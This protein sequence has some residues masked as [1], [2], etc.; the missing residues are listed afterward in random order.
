MIANDPAPQVSMAD[1][2]DDNQPLPKP[3]PPKPINRRQ[4]SATT[5]SRKQSGDENAAPLSLSARP[6]KKS[7]AKGQRPHSQSL[8]H[9]PNQH[10]IE[11]NVMS[12]SALVSSNRQDSEQQVPSQPNLKSSRKKNR[13]EGPKKEVVKGEASSEAVAPGS[14]EPSSSNHCHDF[15]DMMSRSSNRQRSATAVSKKHSGSRDE[16]AAPLAASA[17]RRKQRKQTMAADQRPSIEAL[18]QSV[19]MQPTQE[20]VVLSALSNSVL[21]PSNQSIPQPDP[22]LKPRTSSTTKKRRP[23]M[24][25]GSKKAANEPKVAERLEAD[26]EIAAMQQ[27]KGVDQ[28]QAQTFTEVPLTEDSGLVPQPLTVQPLTAESLPAASVSQPQDELLV[29]ESQSM[30]P[31]D[32][33]QQSVEPSQSAPAQ[34]I[35]PSQSAAVINKP[36]ESQSAAAPQ[37]NVP[38]AAPA[39]GSLPYAVS[40]ESS[41]VDSGATDEESE[42]DEALGTEPKPAASE[43][44]VPHTSIA[45]P[46]ADPSSGSSSSSSSSSESEHSHK[47][48]SSSEDQEKSDS[49]DIGLD[50]ALIESIESV[51]IKKKPQPNKKV[52]FAGKNGSK[53]DIKKLREPSVNFT[54]MFSRNSSG[55]YSPVSTSEGSAESPRRR[56]NQGKKPMSPR[57]SVKVQEPLPAAMAAAHIHVDQTASSAA[58]ANEPQSSKDLVD[59]ASSIR[60]LML[61]AIPAALLLVL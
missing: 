46:P 18:S 56:H 13:D 50:D 3:A 28:N 45:A 6:A 5:G 24:S 29:S 12:R 9:Q 16:N 8:V 41:A 60:P 58:A 15:E 25:K 19:I 30:G 42:S 55:P 22:E 39:D 33:A 49:E 32:V 51:E 34:P 31:S 23:G 44:P 43:I 2:L 47:P 11:V 4:R 17:G 59:S 20:P 35:K 54:A 61:L 53:I 40:T 38:S 14:Q 21:I 7:A 48:S 27:V 52:A 37:S 36:T 10:P 57:A 1:L 26:H